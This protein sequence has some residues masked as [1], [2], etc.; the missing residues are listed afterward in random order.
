MAETKD[1]GPESEQRYDSDMVEYLGN[2]NP[3]VEKNISLINPT[4]AT[5]GYLKVTASGAGAKVC[6]TGPLFVQR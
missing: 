3:V 4:F 6:T 1:R 5:G 2:G